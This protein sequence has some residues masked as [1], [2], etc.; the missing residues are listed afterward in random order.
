MV[1]VVIGV[2]PLSEIVRVPTLVPSL[3]SSSTL[4][5]VFVSVGVV[6]AMFVIVTV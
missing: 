3:A 4:R 2:S 6:S 1:I 5:V